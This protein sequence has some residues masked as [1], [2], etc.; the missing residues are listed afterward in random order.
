MR[1][2]P[3]RLQATDSGP[4][5][6]D[7]T[8][9]SLGRTPLLVTNTPSRYDRPA[10]YRVAARGGLVVVPLLRRLD[11]QHLGARAGAVAVAN[12]LGDDERRLRHPPEGGVELSIRGRADGL[13]R[14]PRCLHHPARDE[15]LLESL[16]RV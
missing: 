16:R 9:S 15:D 3:D 6:S 12:P 13:R 2:S 5:T 14:P 8:S 11:Q 1:A 7:G 10:R 4:G